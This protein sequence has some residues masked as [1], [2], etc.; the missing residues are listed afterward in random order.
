L[1]AD[2]IGT[3]DAVAQTVEPVGQLGMYRARL[4]ALAAPPGSVAA[5]RARAERMHR[6]KEISISS[7]KGRR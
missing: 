1:L 7:S 3:L 4:S 5:L 6:L 2:A